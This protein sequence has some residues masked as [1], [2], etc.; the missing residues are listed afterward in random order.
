MKLSSDCCEDTECSIIVE[1]CREKAA[2]NINLL[3]WVEAAISVAIAALI[4]FYFP[5]NPPQYTGCSAK[6]VIYSK[7]CYY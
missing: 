7:I 3:L 6:I 1:S 2:D 5:S 4:I